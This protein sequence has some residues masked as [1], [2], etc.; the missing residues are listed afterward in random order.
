MNI[1]YVAARRIKL[2]IFS[3]RLNNVKAKM[4]S[5]IRNNIAL[6][7]LIPSLPHF[8]VVLR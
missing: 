1:Q 8:G 3:L 4:L 5:D 6:V 2:C 7:F